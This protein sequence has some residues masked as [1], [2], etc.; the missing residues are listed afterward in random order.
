MNNVASTVVLIIIFLA[1]FGW[2]RWYED[3]KLRADNAG[4]ITISMPMEP[5][6]A[7]ATLGLLHQIVRK[8]MRDR[9]AQNNTTQG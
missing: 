9:E 4:R 6:D 3:Y 8:V 2:G 7:E 1:G 5:E